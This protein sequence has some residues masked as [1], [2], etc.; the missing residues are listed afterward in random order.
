MGS[1]CKRTYFHCR[2]IH[3]YRSSGCGSYTIGSD[4][5]RIIWSI[6]VN[7][8]WGTYNRSRF[9]CSRHRTFCTRYRIHSAGNC[10]CRWS[11][12]NRSSTDSYRYWYRWL[13]SGCPYKSWRR[14]YCDLQSYRRWSTSYRR[15]CKSSRFNSD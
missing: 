1:D 10:R 3:D 2:S 7:W 11:N 15:G 9:T 6:C 4:H 13:N 8:C 12:S 14:D 5:S